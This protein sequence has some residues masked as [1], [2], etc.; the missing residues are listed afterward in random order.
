[1]DGREAGDRGK[2]TGYKTQK[3]KAGNGTEIGYTKNYS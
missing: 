3:A 2:D 1:V